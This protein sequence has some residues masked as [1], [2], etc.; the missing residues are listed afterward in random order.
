L[1]STVFD[2]TGSKNAIEGGMAY[3]RHGGTFVLVGLSKGEL[4]F[5]HPPITRKRNNLIV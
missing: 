3:M 1:A 2:A 4:S 5:Q